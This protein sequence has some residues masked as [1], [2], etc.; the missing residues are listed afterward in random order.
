MVLEAAVLVEAGWAKLVDQ[1]WVVEV[2][3]DTSI[4]R[5]MARNGL[6]KE[7]VSCVTLDVISCLIGYATNQLTAICG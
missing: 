4:R 6:S 7:E 1:V 5:L 2:D 3:Q